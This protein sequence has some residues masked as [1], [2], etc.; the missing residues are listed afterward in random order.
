MAKEI[1]KEKGR[2]LRKKIWRKAREN[3]KKLKTAC[4]QRVIAFT[5]FLEIIQ[6]FVRRSIVHHV[7]V[8]QKTNIV[9]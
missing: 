4:L 7:T 3:S 5:Y 8:S 2:T 1:G 6:R 9:K